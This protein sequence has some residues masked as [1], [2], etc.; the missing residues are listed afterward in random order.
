MAARSM[1]T[2][3]PATSMP[4]FLPIAFK[5]SNGIWIF[6]LLLLELIPCRQQRRIGFRKF[7]RQAIARCSTSRTLSL[8]EPINARCSPT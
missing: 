6:Q 5:S 8:T 4:R 1:F 2:S 3:P 7:E